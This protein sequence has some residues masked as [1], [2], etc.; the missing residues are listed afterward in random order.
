MHIQKLSINRLTYLLLIYHLLF[1]S[2]LFSEADN[3]LPCNNT[4]L[5]INLIYQSNGKGLDTDQKILKEALEQMNF[6]VTIV[7][8]KE[9]KW[10]HA[11]IN[12]FIEN[13]V[14]AKFSWADQNWFIPN[15][16]WYIHHIQLL[17]N[18]D[19]ILCRTR[20]VE[21]IF[22]SMK[23]Q[24]Y[25]LGFTSPDCY[26]PEIEKNY[27]H[28]LH[29][30]GGSPLKGTAALQKIWTSQP[31][32]PLLTVTNFLNNFI[33]QQSN[34]EWMHYRLPEFQLRLL[35]NQCGIHLCP[36][37]AEGFGH[38]IM[39]GMSVGAAI[40]TTDAP[41]MNEFITDPRCLVP[42]YKTDTLFL[43]TRYFVDPQQLQNKIESLL[44]L[45]PE[46]LRRIGLNNRLI[47]LQKTEEFYERLKE[48]M[49]I[50]SFA[51]EK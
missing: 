25:Y 43:A 4:Q 30:A 33:S 3:V 47:Y 38:Y 6:S 44:N 35:Q 48:L 9:T 21:R 10:T 28:F 29:L 15:P 20:E 45:P 51:F 27:F 8:L 14:P 42:C 11:H 24:T 49:W 50:V 31:S 37:E 1:S 41:P 17:D 18:I 23:K 40:I 22:Q 12:I 19:L 7:S 32:L 26:Q 39:E 36:S 2:F 34:L 5:K 46:E 16:E 13:L